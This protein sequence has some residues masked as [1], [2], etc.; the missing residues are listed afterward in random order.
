MDVLTCAGPPE[1]PPETFIFTPVSTGADIIC[2]QRIFETVEICNDI[3]DNCDGFVDGLTELTDINL[4]CD[5]GFFGECAPSLTVCT[6]EAGDPSCTQQQVQ[7]PVGDLPVIQVPNGQLLGPLHSPPCKQGSTVHVLEQPSKLTKLPS[8][9]SSPISKAPLPQTDTDPEKQRA[10]FTSGPLQITKSS[11]GAAEKHDSTVVPAPNFATQKL[12][13]SA[14][15][16]I[17]S[18]QVGFNKGPS[19]QIVLPLAH[20][21]NKPTGSVTGH[22]RLISIRSSTSSVSK[23]QS[24]FI[25]LQTS[26]IGKTF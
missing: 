8:S 9:H 26:S 19:P 16:V 25:P 24:S 12:S 23:S 20:G 14:Q 1:V 7:V 18:L 11:P 5:T 15:E 17:G 13:G 21:P 10:S 22:G 3:D 2:P 6:P 4:T